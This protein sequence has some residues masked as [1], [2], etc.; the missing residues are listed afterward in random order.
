M[1]LDALTHRRHPRHPQ[2]VLLRRA[3]RHHLAASLDQRRQRLSLRV[4]QRAWGGAYGLTE[5]GERLGVEPI[6]LGQAPCGAG[7][8]A[9][10]TRVDD[11]HEQGGDPHLCHQRRLIPPGG[12]DDNELRTKGRQPV[13]EVGD[14]C[15]VV[16][17]VTLVAARTDRNV[18]R[19][20]GHSDPD[21][22]LFPL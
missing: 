7:E 22:H 11:R 9:H 5:V 1:R 8:V 19:R 16:G 17:P 21:D 2:A 4:G 3:H 20:F 14:P 10:L 13:H 15:A 6:R 12:L 18:Q